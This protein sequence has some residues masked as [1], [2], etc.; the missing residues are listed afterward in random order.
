MENPGRMTV[1]ETKWNDAEEARTFRIHAELG[2]LLA[3]ALFHA[4]KET[5]GVRRW[6]S[7]SKGR[8]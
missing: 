7:K 8:A 2:R 4:S 1:Y 3:A 5:R 6:L